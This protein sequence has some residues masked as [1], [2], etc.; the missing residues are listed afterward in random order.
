MKVNVELADDETDRH[1]VESVVEA[2]N[3]LDGETKK[4][5]L[6]EVCGREDNCTDAEAYSAGWDYPPFMGVWGI[7]SP[8]TCPNCTID[9]TA[10]W[11]L[12]SRSAEDQTP[13]PEN[14]LT[15]I[16][17]IMAEGPSGADS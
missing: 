2:A 1:F 11:F 8:R 9:K 12:L 14:H 7:I 4:T 13:I 17:R 5:F 6:C 10:Y 3:H 16:K 15:T